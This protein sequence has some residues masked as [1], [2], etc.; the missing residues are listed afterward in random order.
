MK[1]YTRVIDNIVKDIVDNEIKSLEKAPSEN[2]TKKRNISLKIAINKEIEFIQNILSEAKVI[3]KD[4][5]RFV[6]KLLKLYSSESKNGNKIS[7]KVIRQIRKNLIDEIEN[8]E[9]ALLNKK[10][11]TE[12]IKKENFEAKI[13]KLMAE[14]TKT[15]EEIKKRCINKATTISKD[16]KV[17]ITSK[18]KDKK[19]AKKFKMAIARHKEKLKQEEMALV[20]QDDRFIN[21]IKRTINDISRKLQSLFKTKNT[22]HSFKFVEENGKTSILSQKST[23]ENAF[24]KRVSVDVKKMKKLAELNAGG[25]MQNNKR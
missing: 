25:V 1:D 24:I 16:R 6:K 5:E 21:R 2:V 3:E 22:E 17:Q 18:I 11:K 8:Y 13:D 10:Q 4:K 19:L 14:K 7:A 9:M 12:K 15:K 20:L 23:S